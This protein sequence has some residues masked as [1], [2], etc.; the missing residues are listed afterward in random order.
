MHTGLTASLKE[1]FLD[2]LIVEAYKRTSSEKRK[3]VQYKDI[4]SAV[5]EIDAMEFLMGTQLIAVLMPEHSLS[6]THRGTL[7]CERICAHY[8]HV[9]LA[10]IFHVSMFFGANFLILPRSRADSIPL[11]ERRYANAP[12][13]GTPS[14]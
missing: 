5:A 14:K 13:A 7:C 6:I 1:L 10:P 12:G 3:T 9:F 4:A 2:T 8:I 11:A